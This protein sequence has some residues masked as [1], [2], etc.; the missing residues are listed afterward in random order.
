MT[1]IE[2]DVWETIKLSGH[3]KHNSFD[4]YGPVYPYSN[5]NLDKL[6]S[7]V[8][9]CGKDVLTVASSGDHAFYS[10]NNGANR[11]DLFDINIL[12]KYYYYLR[13]WVIKYFDNFYFDN[14]KLSKKD[15]SIRNFFNIFKITKRIYFD[16]YSIKNVTK[17][18]K[19]LLS[20]VVPTNEEEKQALE[21]WEKV[22]DISI[23]KWGKGGFGY[24]LKGTFFKDDTAKINKISDLSNLREKIQYNNNFNFYNVDI[25]D[26]EFSLNKKYDVIFTSNILDYHY[27]LNIFRKNVFG[28]LKKDGCFVSS[29]VKDYLPQEKIDYLG[30]Y[31]SCIQLPLYK[32]FNKH[33]MPV[34]NVFIKK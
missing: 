33:T 20:L 26:E 2:N 11:V 30:E 16:Q 8:D 23:F 3:Y 6:F 7:C 18:F 24:F 28:L 27:D 29:N 34:G 21:Y 10:Y 12:T 9:V 1:N 22:L 32:S 31:F 4:K 19:Y 17:S 25:L 15:E 14:Y 13:M 5:E